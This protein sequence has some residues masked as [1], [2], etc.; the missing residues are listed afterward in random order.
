MFKPNPA[1]LR[2]LAPVRHP[3]VYAFVSVPAPAAL[4]AA[5]T[6]ATIR[7]PEGLSAVVH[8]GDAVALGLP[9]RMRAAWIMMSAQTALEDVGI[10]AAFA[11][12]L[13]VAGISCN[14]VAGVHHDHLFVPVEHADA[15]LAALATLGRDDSP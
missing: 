14:V 10:T 8:E 15:A 1:V 7:E 9:I 5:E 12:A 2:A 3:G 11:H 4:A 6:L 13:A